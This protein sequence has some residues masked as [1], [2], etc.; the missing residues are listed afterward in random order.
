MSATLL[1]SKLDEMATALH[2]K[3]PFSGNARG[4][5]KFL[6]ENADEFASKFGLVV[7]TNNGDHSA[8]SFEPDGEQLE[9]LRRELALEGFSEHEDMVDDL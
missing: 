4:L 7:G 2:T 1:C 6:K 8:Y 5:G 3:N 9:A